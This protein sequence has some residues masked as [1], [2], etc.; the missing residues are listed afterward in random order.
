MSDKKNLETSKIKT[1]TDAADRNFLTDLT[2]A[3]YTAV[4]N[5][6]DSFVERIAENRN[7]KNTSNNR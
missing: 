3:F 2:D 6:Y 1:S 7:K 5:S 4:K